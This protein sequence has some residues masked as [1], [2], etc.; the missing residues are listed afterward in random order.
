MADSQNYSNHTRWFPLV[1]FVIFPLLIIN[2]LC[3]VVRLFMAPGWERGFWTLLSFVFILMVLAARQQALK[4]Q[5]RTIRLEER[6]RYR[7]VLSPELEV[8][9]AGLANGQIIA[10]RFASDAELP[11]LVER[12]LKG[13]FAKTKDIKMAIKDWRPDHMR[14]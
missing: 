9:A 3:H 2:F 4:A 7:D 5:D 14:V 11:D 6:L 12:T 8:K 10:L 13:E 1:H